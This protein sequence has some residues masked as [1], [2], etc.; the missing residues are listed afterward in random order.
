M[1]LHFKIFSFKMEKSNLLN[2]TFIQIGKEVESNFRSCKVIGFY[3]FGNL[4]LDSLVSIFRF[5][6]F[7]I[8][9]HFLSLGKEYFL[10]KILI[11]FDHKW[12]W[13]NYH[14]F[15]ILLFFIIIYLGG[16]CS[17]HTLPIIDA[18]ISFLQFNRF[19]CS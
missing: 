1:K 10:F 19:L 8:F 18:D 16:E 5:Y 17:V 9:F 11:L 3:P 7:Y 6:F 14:I 4:D 13:I 2:L 12:H 15:H